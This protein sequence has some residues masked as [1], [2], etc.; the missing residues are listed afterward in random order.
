MGN[1]VRGVDN[2]VEG[3]VEQARRGDALFAETFFTC[4]KLGQAAGKAMRSA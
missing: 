1:F 4:G 3:P 2:G